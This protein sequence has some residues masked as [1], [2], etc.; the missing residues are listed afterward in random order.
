MRAAEEKGIVD[1]SALDVGTV[2][3][4]GAASYRVLQPMQSGP[5]LPELTGWP[6]NTQDTP[7]GGLVP[8]R[9]ATCSAGPCTNSAPPRRSD[10]NTL[11]NSALWREFA[12]SHR[13]SLRAPGTVSAV[14]WTDKLP[15]PVHVGDRAIERGRTAIVSH[16]TIT[17]DALDSV[18][19][20]IEAVRDAD[21]RTFDAPGTVAPDPSMA[22]NGL[23]YR[24]V[25]PPTVGGRAIDF[26]TVTIRPPPGLHAI[27]VPGGHG[28]TILPEQTDPIAYRLSSDDVV[29]GVVYVRTRLA[30]HLDGGADTTG[31]QVAI[32]DGTGAR[33]VVGDASRPVSA[34]PSGLPAG[35]S[36]GPSA[37]PS[38][39]PGSSVPRIAAPPVALPPAVPDRTPQ[40][41]ATSLKA[42]R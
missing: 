3:A 2:A 13:A 26:A 7:N 42:A 10:G 21:L 11:V 32:G 1:Q 18:G 19:V 36:A 22:V 23:L 6:I 33:I 14:G 15:A 8:A 20:R 12:R 16:A 5:P 38:A 29:N 4:H 17:V 28:W 39:T 40:V 41:T 25:L 31:W 27:A 24:I 9:A 35:S 37:G 34:Q 30:D